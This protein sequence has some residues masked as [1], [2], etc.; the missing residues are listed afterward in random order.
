MCAKGLRVECELPCSDHRQRPVVVVTC[1]SL[2]WR[3]VVYAHTV[4][5]RQ[6]GRLW[7]GGELGVGAEERQVG[8]ELGRGE[9]GTTQETWEGG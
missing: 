1:H 7:E 2:S 3:V 9:R 8:V 6:L 5:Q 4:E